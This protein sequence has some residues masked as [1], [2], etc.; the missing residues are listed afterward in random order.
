[1]KAA[2]PFT[3]SSGHQYF[4][5]SH[6]KQFLNSHPLI[7]HFISLSANTTRF[8]SF[9]KST[10]LKHTIH[11]PGIGRFSQADFQYYLRKY[12]FLRKN[13]FFKPG[14]QKNREGLVPPNR[15]EQ[16]LAQTKQIIFETTE[17]CN[18][19]CIYCTYSKFYYNK[20]RDRNN[21]SQD[22]ALKLLDL[23]LGKRRANP[24]QELAVSF[25]GGEPLKNFS[26]IEN[27]V[28][29][30][31]NHKSSALRI[32][33]SMTTNGLLLKKYI[34]YLVENDFELAI[35]LD[36]D[37]F[38]N[39]FRVLKTNRKPSFELVSR[40]IDMVREKY[41]S[42]FDRRVIF[43]TVRHSRNSLKTIHEYFSSKYGKTPIMS[44]ITTTG[45]VGECQDEFRDT[46]L[47][48]QLPSDDNYVYMHE[49]FTRHPFISETAEIFERF[50][51]FVFRKPKQLLNPKGRRKDNIKY[52]PTATCSPFDLRIYMSADGGIYPCE[53]ISRI[54]ELGAVRDSLIDLDPEKITGTYNDYFRKIRKLC[55]QC[56]L[57]DNCKECIFN[58]G[59]ETG[60]PKC[61]FFMNRDKFT[62]YLI[63]I[64]DHLENDQLLFA[65]I[66]DEAFLSK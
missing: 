55:N 4:Y 18:L 49:M 12:H 16:N 46:F 48:S 15:I 47:K 3:T 14:I 23:V 50:G 51:G 65:R 5:S 38:A 59:I 62:S 45:V 27:I 64:F 8:Q 10:G 63:Q 61:E 13:G 28:N 24:D 6:K 58:T 33:Y 20:K 56:F 40:N 43:L 60:I 41:P 30:V 29:H 22:D 42:Y 21:I 17:D 7:N 25:Y 11:I 66:R 54:F 1:M 31:N 39:S 2:I 32:K 37:E 9:I 57:S 53:H 19:D 52:L 35:S 26:F 44:T 36:G 34:A